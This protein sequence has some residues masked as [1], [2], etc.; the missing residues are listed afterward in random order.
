MIGLTLV[1]TILLTVVVY[2]KVSSEMELQ[3]NHHAENINQNV[4]TFLGLTAKQIEQL[5]MSILANDDIQSILRTINLGPRTP[6]ITASITKHVEDEFLKMTLGREEIRGLFLISNSGP[7][8]SLVLDPM[9]NLDIIDSAQILK[10]K[11]ANGS[12]VWLR[13]DSK[14]KTIPMGRVYID[15][16][17][18]KPAGILVI[19]FKEQYFADLFKATKVS[20]S[21]SLYLVSDAGYIISHQDK[22][23]LGEL[24]DAPFNDQIVNSTSDLSTTF[25]AQGQQYHLWSFYMPDFRWRLVS[26]LPSHI[27]K[28]PAKRLQNRMFLVASLCWVAAILLG[29]IISRGITEPIQ[30]L[31]SAIQGFTVN[32][33]YPRVTWSSGDEIGNA[34]QAYN[35]LLDHLEKAEADLYEANRAK[36]DFLMN[37]SHELRTPLNGII[38]A[39]ELISDDAT[40][41]HTKQIRE[42]ISVSGQNL[43]ELIERIFEFTKSK[44]GEI[45]LSYAPFNLRESLAGLKTR[46]HHRNAETELTLSI[47]PLPEALPKNL[48]GDKSHLIEVLTLMLENSAKFTQ[49][50]PAVSLGIEIVSQ[51][52]DT[53]GLKFSLTDNG[54]GIDRSYHDRIFEP[55]YQVDSS[56]TRKYQGVG[57]GLAICKQLVELM[58]GEIGVHSTPGE[59]S[60]FF[61]Q[62]DFKIPPE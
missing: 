49:D 9:I 44:D 39:A 36:G 21:E 37:M 15:T 23:R 20:T 57:I 40:P 3:F 56:I 42:I 26:I 41:D 17:T 27:I 53:L 58:D 4:K 60:T 13:T 35:Q 31:L 43:L 6:T 62:L 14:S 33:N 7:A 2:K 45:E 12:P 61:F 16:V 30:R 22:S 54:I 18:Q 55:F 52:E 47:E 1:S 11:V 48:I 50:P 25:E 8:F 51:T 19:F 32:K 34:V 38:L 24:L 29:L 10:I 5:S 28:Q 59:G 46:F